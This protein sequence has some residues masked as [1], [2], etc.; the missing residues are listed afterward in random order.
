MPSPKDGTAGSAVPP[1]D[2]KK[3]EEADKAEPG[4]V[5]Q[6]KAEQR[7]T[8]TGKYGST[9]VKPHKPPQTRAEKQ[10]KPSWIQIKL[11]D[12]EGKPVPGERY[13]ITLPDGET[14]AE[15]TL[16]EKGFARVDGI[17]PGSCKITFPE[18]DK[19][20]WKRA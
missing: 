7:Q 15:G 16:D 8:K 12:D 6:I 9:P 2:P 4:E 3:A 19:T 5:A 13:K 10:K 1:A 18:L 17:E 14:V 11:K 20:A